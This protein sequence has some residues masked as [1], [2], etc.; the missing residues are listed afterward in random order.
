[1]RVSEGRVGNDYSKSYSDKTAYIEFKKGSKVANFKPFVKSFSINRKYNTKHGQKKESFY[2]EVNWQFD[3]EQPVYSLSFE[4]PSNSI[5]EAIVNHSKFQYLMRMVYPP[6]SDNNEVLMQQ[7][8]MKFTN[9]ISDNG[10]LGGGGFGAYDSAISEAKRIKKAEKLG[11]SDELAKKKSSDIFKPGLV[12]ARGTTIEEVVDPN[13]SDPLEEVEPPFRTADWETALRAEDLFTTKR[14]DFGTFE[15]QFDFLNKLNDPAGNTPYGPN[16]NGGAGSP[17]LVFIKKLT[18][19]PELPMGF[20]EY[21]G[22]I[23]PKIF[24]VSLSIEVGSDDMGLLK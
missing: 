23:F 8:E 10:I 14:P 13:A 21:S 11:L 1:M 9:L 20:F 18:Y 17:V 15:E 4:V 22:M 3:T 16:K 7:I 19:K 5:N 6:H 24:S 12:A 2:D